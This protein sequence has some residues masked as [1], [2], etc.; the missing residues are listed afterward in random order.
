MARKRKHGRKGY[1]AITL[2]SRSSKVS[3]A[4]YR[5]PKKSRKV[6][7]NVYV[8]RDIMDSAGYTAWACTAKPTG[9]GLRASSS[10]MVARSARTCGPDQH[11]KTPTAAL[12]RA[13]VAFG[14]SKALK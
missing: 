7:I 3:K 10:R 9:S 4:Y 2:R 8:T 11:A 6:G 1:G 13:L 5:L 12:K 14:K